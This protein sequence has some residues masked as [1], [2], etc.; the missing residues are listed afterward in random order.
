MYTE[1]EHDGDDE[2]GRAVQGDRQRILSDGYVD[3]QRIAI[4]VGVDVEG[5]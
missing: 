4:T 2:D 1:N 3:S 5:R